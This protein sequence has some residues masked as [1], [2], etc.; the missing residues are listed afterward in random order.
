M[1]VSGTEAKAQQGD[2]V[3][4]NIDSAIATVTLNRPELHN[5]FNEV[6]IEALD[7]AFSQLGQNP[8][9]RAIILRSEGKSFCAGADLNWMQRMIDYDFTQNV[10]D[11]RGLA[12][13]LKTIRT[14][15]KP[16]IGRVQGAALGGG[17]GLV[18]VCDLAITLDSAI[19]GLTEVK[20]GIMPA[21]I[22]PFV[23]EKIGNA[24]ASR[25]FLTAERFNAEE[26]KRINL[27]THIVQTEAEMDDWIHQQINFILKN[28][29]EAVSSC[30]TMIY[31]VAEAIGEEAEE[32]TTRLI[33]ERR[34]SVEGQEGIKAFL[35]KRKPSWTATYP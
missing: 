1:S 3:Q 27:V 4:V 11:A 16:I 5:A 25:Y 35:E 32:I 12:R 18:S 22:S 19:F 7:K 20:L 30:K 17:V 31:E 33:A 26:A 8:D 13:M 29:P 21:V 24:H 23:I 28:G 15:P 14:C 2:F 34:V 9:I 10:E 6:F